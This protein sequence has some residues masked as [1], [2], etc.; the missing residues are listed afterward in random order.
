VANVAFFHLVLLAFDLVHWFRRL[1]LSADYETATVE[2]VRTD[3]LVLPARLV[4]RAGR[5]LLQLP[6]DYLHRTE[7]VAAFERAGKLRPPKKN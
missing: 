3:F 1:C 2:T 4:S 7:F 6:R 5:N